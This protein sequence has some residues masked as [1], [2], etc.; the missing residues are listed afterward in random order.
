MLHQLALANLSDALIERIGAGDDVLLQYGT[1]WALINGHVDNAKLLALQSKCCQLY[2]LTEAL[3]VN[4]IEP[5][6]I[7]TGVE[8]ID[9]AGW[10]ALTVKNPVIHTWN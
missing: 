1:L 6:R 9:Y 3:Q 4:G 10:V 7:M 2:V 5:E 8:L